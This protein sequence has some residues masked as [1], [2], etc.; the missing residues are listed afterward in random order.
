MAKTRIH[1]LGS[2]DEVDLLL[3][4]GISGGAFTAP[5]FDL[6]GKTLILTSP[7]GETV[8]FATTPAGTQVPTS[9]SDILDQIRT[10]TT[11]VIV[12]AIKRAGNQF[13]LAL[14]HDSASPSAI[15]LGVG[16]ANTQ[17]GFSNSQTGKV[18]APYDGVA[19]R[20]FSITTSPTSDGSFYVMTEE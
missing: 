12:K 8:T 1:R 17:L 11:D 20:W 2:R 10:Q 5:L 19:P 13:S 16:T 4:G 9:I 15:T 7:A 18:Y 6:N 14:V 3:Q